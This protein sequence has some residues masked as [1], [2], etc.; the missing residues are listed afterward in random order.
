M[1]ATPSPLVTGHD[2]RFNSLES[3]MNRDG[4]LD[5]AEARPE[6]RRPPP[7]PGSGWRALGAGCEWPRHRKRHRCGMSTVALRLRT[8]TAPNTAMPPN[9]GDYHIMTIRITSAQDRHLERIAQR[10]GLPKAACIRLLID[11]DMRRGAASHN[12]L[13]A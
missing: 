1:G 12:P 7:D 9:A 2:G 4:S 13:T 3:P 5:C 6:N 8:A 11:A 10:Q